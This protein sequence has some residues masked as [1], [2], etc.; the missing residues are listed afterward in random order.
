[1]TGHA[2]PMRDRAP[3][4]TDLA[5]PQVEA[6]KIVSCPTASPAVSELNGRFSL[7]ADGTLR[8]STCIQY[9][10]RV[11]FGHGRTTGRFF[12]GYAGRGGQKTR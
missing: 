10:H 8:S 7:S 11:Q 6:S 12:T 5:V 4:C 2:G 9:T 3:F 1:M